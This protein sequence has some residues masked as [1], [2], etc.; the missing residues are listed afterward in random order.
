MP[1]IQFPFE[2]IRKVE[3]REINSKIGG[4]DYSIYVNLLDSQ[5]REI[6]PQVSEW[7]FAIVD[8][9]SQISNYQTFYQTVGELGRI[10]MSIS[11][12]QGDF[13]FALIGKFADNNQIVSEIYGTIFNE[14]VTTTTTLLPET[15]QFTISLTGNATTGI[16]R[17]VLPSYA[18]DFYSDI[19]GF[20]AEFCIVII[21]DIEDGISYNITCTKNGSDYSIGH[22]LVF[23]GYQYGGDGNIEITITNLPTTTTTTTTVDPTSGLILYYDIGSTE[24]YDGSSTLIDLSGSGYNGNIVNASFSTQDGGSLNFDGNSYVSTSYTVPFIDETVDFTWNVWIKSK[25]LSGMPIIGNRDNY[26]LPINFIKIHSYSFEYFPT[27]GS[28]GNISITLPINTWVNVCIVKS[29]TT[30]KYYLNGNLVG[31]SY[32]VGPISDTNAFYLGADPDANEYSNSQVA[33]VKIY[34]RAISATEVSDNYS[35]DVTRFNII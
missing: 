31:Q 9:N 32:N 14:S 24:C 26:S 19:I 7:G 1:N 22:R 13:R 25:I 2:I 6:H 15:L 3:F 10:T 16:Y 11:D 5:L 30:I 18:E 35:K 20:G 4:C 29:G 17:G 33:I 8:E 23:Y 12:I 21:N 28:S 34:D 27:S